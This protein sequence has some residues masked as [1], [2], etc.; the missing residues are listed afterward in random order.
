MNL[1][2]QQKYRFFKKEKNMKTVVESTKLNKKIV[3]S[4]PYKIQCD[5][6]KVLILTKISDVKA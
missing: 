6:L 5:T 4:K 1:K 3:W 2:E